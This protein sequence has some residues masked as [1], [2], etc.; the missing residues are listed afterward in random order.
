MAGAVD[1]D[2]LTQEEVAAHLRDP[3]WGVSMLPRLA[4]GVEEAALV[5]NGRPL[6]R[7]GRT[8]VSPSLPGADGAEE[9]AIVDEEEH[10]L[11]VY[12]GGPTTFT[13]EIVLPS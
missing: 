3:L 1:P 10:L 7:A 4:V 5:R 12:R 11:A 9:V 6:D 2:G 8:P 13:P